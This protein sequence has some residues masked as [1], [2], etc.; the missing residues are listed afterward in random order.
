MIINPLAVFLALSILLPASNLAAEENL[1]KP[2]GEA[3]GAWA[4]GRPEDA[5]GSLEYVAFRSSDTALTIAAIKELSVVLAEMGKN[6]EALAQISR[7]EI[8]APEDPYLAFEKGWN[9]L[10][11]EDH[12]EA[13][14]AF[15]KSLTL[16]AEPYLVAQARFGLALAEAHLVGPAKTIAGLQTVY[17]TYPYLLSPAAEVISEQYEVLKQRPHSIT[18]LKEALTYDPRNIQAE[19]DLARIYDESGFY[20]PAWQTY[21]TISDLDPEDKYAADKTA[22]LLKY[23]TGK[24]DNLLYWTRM[25]WPVHTKP[26]NYDDKDLVRCGLFSDGKGEPSVLTEFTF[27]ANTDFSITDS[28]L[29]PVGGGKAN[30]QWNVKYNPMNKIYEIRDT[31]GSVIHSTRN[32]FRLTPAVKGGIILI[33][34]PEPVTQRGV[35]RGDREVTGELNLL[36]KEGGFRVINTVPLEVLVPSVVTSLAG[37][38]TR[39]EE[40]KALAVVVRSKLVHLK[41]SKPHQ[42]RDYDICDS[43]HCLM[44]P[45]LQAENEAVLKAADLTRGEVLS[46]DGVPVAGD[47]HTAC[48]GLTEEGISDNGRTPGRLTPFNLYRMTMQAP[49]DD[50]LCLPEDK[51]KASDVVWTLLLE[52]KW[53]ENRLNQSVKIGYIRSM[54]VLKRAANGKVL[55]L[56]VEGTAGSTVLEGFAAVSHA[57]TGGAMR[58][59]LFTMRPIFEGKYPKYFIL[60][61]IGTGDGHGYCLLGARGMAKGFGYKYAAIL[62][63][64][65]P[66]YKV[67]KLFK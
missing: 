28:R 38:S 16:T 8:L 53:I 60:R 36:V 27:I 37:R 61:G 40:L 67:K 57:L 18:F 22:A 15:E 32:S 7:A 31:M 26:L 1:L 59:A 54:T 23:V 41:S 29:G 20:L 42:D 25:T 3:F 5:A 62:Q 51:T 45:G 55:S 58:S 66:Y 13:R 33:K 48:G 64:Y 10:S 46:K 34:N 43:A 6:R 21:Y 49:P 24:P 9:L 14:N 47:F 63:H 30:M 52:P 50:L 44:L 65:F 19:L 35:N 12:A 17:N 4:D 2:L 39:L 11:L 56:R